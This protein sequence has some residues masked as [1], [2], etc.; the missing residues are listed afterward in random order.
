MDTVGTKT[1]CLEYGSIRNSGASVILP[2]GIVICSRTD[3]H[4]EVTFSDLAFAVQ[5]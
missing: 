3:E 1:L 4:K 2:V 5:C